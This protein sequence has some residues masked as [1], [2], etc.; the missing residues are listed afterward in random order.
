MNRAPFA[1]IIIPTFNQAAYLQAALESLI[2]QTDGDWEAVVVNDGSTDNTREVAE[3]YAGTDARI[4]VFHQENGGVAAALNM[5]LCEARGAWIHW[6]SSDDLFEPEKLATNRLWIDRH[7]ETNFFFSHFTLLRQSTGEKDRRGLWGPLPR[8]EHQILTLFYR[9]YISGISICVRRSAWDAVGNFDTGLRYAQDYD[10]WLRLL[11]C[12]QARFIPEWTVIS[13]NH[14]EQ[15]S[16]TFPDACYFDTAKAA[17]RFINRHRFEELVPWVNLSDPLQAEE[18]V[19]AALDVACNPSSFIYCMGVHPGLVLRVLEWVFSGEARLASVEQMVRDRVQ[20]MSFQESE[21]DWCWMWRRLAIGLTDEAPRVTYDAVDPLALAI[22]QWR[23]MRLDD[24]PKHVAMRSYLQRFDLVDP[25]EVSPD[26][27]DKS[28][29]AFVLR[30]ERDDIA[31]FMSAARRLSNRGMRPVVLVQSV[32]GSMPTLQWSDGVPIIA[33]RSLDRNTLPWL[34]NVELAV[35]TTNEPLTWLGSFMRLSIADAND[36]QT[37]ERRVI[38][39]LRPK[40]DRRPIV[41]LERVLWGGGAERVVHDLARHLDATRYAV[42]VVTMFEEHSVGPK[43]PR[44]ILLHSLYDIELAGWNV[45]VQN[46]WRPLAMRVLR[47]AYHALFPLSLRQNLG[48]G[49]TLRAS[50]RRY[51]AW[52]GAR[53]LRVGGGAVDQDAEWRTRQASQ[54]L[55]FDFIRPMMLYNPVAVKF[56]GFLAGL[57][58]RALVMSVME[59]AAVTANLARTT[60]SFDHIG[61]LHTLESACM[62]DI[63]RVEDRYRAEKRLLSSACREADVVTFPSDGCCE[64]LTRHFDVPS[65]QIRKIWNPLDCARIGHLAQRRLEACENWRT[66][67]RGFRMVSVGRL[68]PQKNHDLLLDACALLK[69]QG[70]SFSLAIVGDG[71]YR[72][73]IEKRIKALELD[74][75][76]LFCGVQENPFPWIT[77][78]DALVL[79]SRFEAFAL[80]LAEA[81]ACGTPAVAVDCPTG[82]AEV[83]ANGEFGLLADQNAASLSECLTRL[84]NDEALRESLRKRGYARAELFDIK[85]IVAEWDGLI[86]T[87]V[88]QEK[89]GTKKAK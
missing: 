29:V 72:S 87:V 41:F 36:A 55:S 82:P 70:K 11:Q 16:E 80:V 66:A 33:V 30:A 67:N 77:A 71:W 78:S 34:G 15:G 7:P 75:Q 58:E 12:N 8:P 19:R 27:L 44:H 32:E 86:E 69:R 48:I 26:V 88:A 59:E 10:Q 6:L 9:N 39:M 53:A 49:S 2:D 63:H 20:Q 23:A 42:S 31:L 1:S 4:R 45:V 40:E 85:K 74:K 56:A 25:E 14:A 83:L 18:A 89:T 3:S 62:R 54:D 81:M 17:I 50:L 64:D 84:M 22:G 35:T 37:L 38:D 46:G 60:V 5:G 43:W 28:R 65:A 51:N 13:R 47:K 68:D 52:R 21:D 73:A 24:D 76:V 61:T 57:Q 79:T